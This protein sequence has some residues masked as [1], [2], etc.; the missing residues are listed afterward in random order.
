MNASLVNDNW[1]HL[2][3]YLAVK[4]RGYTSYSR[5]RDTVKTRYIQRKEINEQYPPARCPQ[6]RLPKLRIQSGL[7]PTI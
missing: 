3:V 1:S 6:Y 4:A 7:F 2:S 5:L